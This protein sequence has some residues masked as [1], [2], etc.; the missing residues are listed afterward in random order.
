[1]DNNN[2]QV[3]TKE[4]HDKLH[5]ERNRKYYDKTMICP[6]CGKEFLWAAY[7]QQK[8]HSNMSRTKPRTHHSLGKPF[9]SKS[10]AGKYGK[11]VQMNYK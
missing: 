3:L 11:F 1:M 10:C 8:F 7:Q 9:C 4:E 5:G 2:L 6:W